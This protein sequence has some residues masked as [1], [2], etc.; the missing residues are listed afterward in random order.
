VGICH[1]LSQLFDFL[2]YFPRSPNG[3]DLVNHSAMAGGKGKQWKTREEIAKVYALL[4]IQR[5]KGLM[6]GIKVREGEPIEKILRIFKKQV[7][8]AGVIG[9]LKKYQHYEKP[10]IKRKKKSIAARKRRIKQM[11][12]MGVAE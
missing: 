7:E 1:C 10:S 3:N 12:K 4:P 8:K 6:P 5:R 9:D 2:E 11:R